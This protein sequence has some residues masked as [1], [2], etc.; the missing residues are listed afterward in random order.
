[1]ISGVVGLLLGLR[2][3]ILPAVATLIT[4]AIG[5]LVGFFIF[6]YALYYIG[7][8]QGG[9]GTLDE[10]FYT[11]ALYVVPL[12]AVGGLLGAARLGGIGGL[13]GLLLAIYQAYLGYLAARSSMN[14]DQNKAII[15]IVL[16]I[17]AS[18]L[19]GIVVGIV[20][21]LLLAPLWIAAALT[22]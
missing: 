6:A 20:L 5:T 2:F 21:G 14:L 7:K 9:T 3:G 1:M 11:C 16:A 18:I 4:A 17:I 22:S 15:T 8:Q 10:V 19:A 13:I 12:Q